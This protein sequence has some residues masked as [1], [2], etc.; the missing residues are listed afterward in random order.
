MCSCFLYGRGIVGGW[1]ECWNRIGGRV[2]STPAS[3]ATR[4]GTSPSFFRRISPVKK[5]KGKN[6]VTTANSGGRG[7]VARKKGGEKMDKD[8]P[9][10]TPSR[11]V[12]RRH[13]TI[14]VEAASSQP[15]EPWHVYRVNVGVSA[16][17]SPPPA[18]PPPRSTE[19]APPMPPSR[20]LVQPS[21]PMT[22]DLTFST[23][24]TVLAAR[25]A[26]YLRSFEGAGGEGDGTVASS[27]SMVLAVN[28]DEGDQ[29]EGTV[30]SQ[31]SNT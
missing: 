2:V 24:D 18:Q 10:K 29:Y 27:R 21:T 7:Q 30:S 3:T 8:T 4:S 9:P 23:A 6:G 13:S 26:S 16:A 17:S 19:P 14:S 15:K 25:L 5:R 31:G 11:W 1:L 12:R 22:P 28:E 20:P